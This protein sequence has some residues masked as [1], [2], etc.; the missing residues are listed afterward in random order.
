MLERERVNSGINSSLS[1]VSPHFPMTARFIL[2]GSPMIKVMRITH[3]VFVA[4]KIPLIYLLT[5][6]FGHLRF[7]SFSNPHRCRCWSVMHATLFR[8]NS[9]KPVAGKICIWYHAAVASLYYTW[10]YHAQ[11]SILITIAAIPVLNRQLVKT[12]KHT[13]EP[14]VLWPVE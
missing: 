9:F 10:L 8:P 2:D 4:Y 1:V 7:W 5:G 12:R 11:S 13:T 6:H 3:S 14:D